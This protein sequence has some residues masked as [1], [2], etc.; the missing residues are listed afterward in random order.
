MFRRRSARLAPALS[1]LLDAQAA[2]RQLAPFTPVRRELR[3][4]SV[5]HAARLVLRHAGATDDHGEIHQING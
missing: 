3:R 5:Q 1:E 4:N 2:A